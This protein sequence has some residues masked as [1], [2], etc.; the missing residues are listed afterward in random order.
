MNREMNTRQRVLDVSCSLFY[1]NGFNGTS[2]RDIA[3]KAKV[4]VSLI[5]YYFKSKQG[6]FESLAIQYFEPYLEMIEHEAQENSET[7]LQQLIKGILHYKQVHYQLSCL[8]YRELS[9][10][11]VFAKEMLVTYLAKEN[12][13]LS[14]ILFDKNTKFELSYR[15]KLC[16]LQFKG[17]LNVPHMMPQEFEGLYLSEES[18]HHFIQIY[19]ELMKQQDVF[20]LKA[21]IS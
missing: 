5:H 19:A 10:N 9:L 3:K 7:D 12:H 1:S 20:N 6:L 17:L 8:V 2:V 14:Q 11:T 4:N 15:E 21:V 16:L 13:L 18:I